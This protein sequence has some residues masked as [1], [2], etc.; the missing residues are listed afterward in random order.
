MTEHLITIEKLNA[1]GNSAIKEAENLFGLRVENKFNGFIFHDNVPQLMGNP[2]NGYTI[3]VGYPGRES[4][5]EAIFQTAHEVIHL[6]NP[7]S[8]WNVSV[9][10]EGLAV[11]FSLF[12]LKNYGFE[13][14]A[15]HKIDVLKRNDDPK[16]YQAYELASLVEGLF[17]KVKE[18]R[19]EH[20]VGLS[21][22][23][24]EHLLSLG[25]EDELA[26]KLIVKFNAK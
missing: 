2:N 24:Q 16:Y 14:E 7:I 21:E 22:C 13:D 25:I 20:G 3:K 10:E 23:T 1:I 17:D 11:S 15:L 4:D 9:L 5:H 12:Y 18:L 8:Y 19:T 6:L 26:A